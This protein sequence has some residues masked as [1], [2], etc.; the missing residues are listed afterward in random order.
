[1]MAREGEDQDEQ[2]ERHMRINFHGARHLVEAALPGMRARGYGRIVNVASSAA[3]R[4]YAYVA[5]Y[6]AS[7]HALLGYTLAAADEL[8]GKGVTVNAVCPH[9]VDS[10]M[11]AASIARVVEKTG[12]SPKEAREFFRNVNPGR[13]IVTMDEVA[14]AVYGLLVDDEAPNGRVVELDGST[15]P[16]NLQPNEL[17]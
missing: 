9:Y 5:A 10:P 1:M 3:L 17:R 15:D 16:R 11:L 6:C 14:D 2:Y 12:K 13:R 4:G 7:K 8:S